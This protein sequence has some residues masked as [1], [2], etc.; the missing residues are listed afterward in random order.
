MP[1][2]CSHLLPPITPHHVYYST[3]LPSSLCHDCTPYS[4]VAQKDFGESQ[5]AVKAF[6]LWLESRCGLCN[7][8]RGGESERA[9]VSVF[10]EATEA[11]W[12]AC[13]C[14][15]QRVV[16][17]MERSSKSQIGSKE[18]GDGG[19]FGSMKRKSTMTTQA[20]KGLNPVQQQQQVQNVTGGARSEGT[21]AAIGS[22]NSTSHHESSG[23]GSDGSVITGT[24]AGAMTTSTSGA[25]NAVQSGHKAGKNAAQRRPTFNSMKK[26]GTSSN[27]AG[28]AAMS[29]NNTN[30]ITSASST[31]ASE[32]QQTKA[33]WKHAVKKVLE[34]RRRSSGLFAGVADIGSNGD[35]ESLPVK[36]SFLRNCI[37]SIMDKHRSGQLEDLFSVEV[38]PEGEQWPWMVAL[39][40]KNRFCRVVSEL[41]RL[42]EMLRRYPFFANLPPSF[43]QWVIQSLEVEDLSPQQQIYARGEQNDKIYVI[44]GGSVQLSAPASSAKRRARRSV[45]D[46][47]AGDG[48]STVA[49][50][51]GADVA[52]VESP[53]MTTG[54]NGVQVVVAAGDAFGD[55]VLTG[56]ESK[57]Y[58]ATSIRKTLCVTLSKR[59]HDMLLRRSTDADSDDKF[60]SLLLIP[61]KDRTQEQVAEIEVAVNQFSFFEKMKPDL[62][63][64]LCHSIDFIEL[65]EGHVIF[66]QGDEGD[67]FY[68]VLKGAVD[69]YIGAMPAIGSTTTESTTFGSASTSASSPSSSSDTVK[70]VVSLG[71]GAQFGELSLIE[72]QP[73]AGAAVTGKRTELALL[74]KGA[75]QR[76][77][78]RQ[79]MNH[80]KQRVDFLATLNI[81]KHVRQTILFKHSYFFTERTF[82]RNDVISQQGE[83]PNEVHFVLHG[84]CK[85]VKTGGASGSRGGVEIALLGVGDAI[86]DYAAVVNTVQPYSAIASSINVKTLSIKT[87]NIGNVTDDNTLELLRS[88]AR[89]KHM[90]Y[91]QRIA[92]IN[93]TQNRL[94]GRSSQ[95]GLAKG[96]RGSAGL[97]ARC[98]AEEQKPKPI[99]M[100]GEVAA[101]SRRTWIEGAAGGGRGAGRN[102][103][104]V[105]GTS[106]SGKARLRLALATDKDGGFTGRQPFPLRSEMRSEYYSLKN[107]NHRNSMNSGELKKVGTGTTTT[108]AAKAAQQHIEATRRR[109]TGQGGD[110]LSPDAGRSR[111]AFSIPAFHS[112]KGF[113]LE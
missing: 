12:G 75:Y 37:S 91:E 47:L 32:K 40:R 87:S 38:K 35:D 2:Y 68:I 82:G 18:D 76:T 26:R 80:L 94:R 92:S 107:S 113:L 21:S 22:Q 45:T 48:T 15:R 109:L 74:T 49:T 57:D 95:G 79:H 36:A 100:G 54:P 3:L 67:C 84:E 106:T 77:L 83:K 64:E 41:R 52:R 86:G 111:M 55:E 9:C 8:G 43:R 63:K 24:T 17:W 78:K 16:A 34:E 98:G 71:P 61:K 99:S 51:V 81:F 11:V 88:I 104:C 89:D 44:L 20:T 29:S 19:G 97:R 85:L 28:T 110:W 14:E 70:P 103:A 23:S 60:R 7:L 56:R 31:T 108:R 73:R 102:D 50:D 46:F 58:T 42:S 1:T 39:L 25:E 27:V 5:E 33:K 59:D 112:K 13:V 4:C 10:Y 62:R 53:V 93:E 72:N 69:I 6:G 90:W 65:Q 105:Y 96:V 30:T 101:Q 66:N